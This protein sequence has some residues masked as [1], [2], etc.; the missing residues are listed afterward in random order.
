MRRAL[1]L[2]T[3]A[4]A[5]VA[6][7]VVGAAL[8][9]RLQERQA[10]RLEDRSG[11]PLVLAPASQIAADLDYP[12]GGIAVSKEGR[13]FVTLHP[14]GSPPVALVEMRG[15]TP[16]PYPNLEFQEKFASPLAT[17]IDGENRLWVLDYGSFGLWP[18]RLYIFYLDVDGLIEEH[19]LGDVAGLLSMFADF[20]IDPS[21]T[22][23][24]L[25]DSSPVLGNPSIVVYDTAKNSG[26][27][28]LEGHIA[29]Q[30]RAYVIQAP[31]REV[32]L[33]SGAPLAVAH[34]HVALDA[35]GE[36]LYIARLTG[37]R[38]Y[39]VRTADLKDLSLS[40]DE[41]ARRVEDV[42][43]KPLGGGM[44]S[45]VK[46]NLYISDPEHSAVIRVTPEGKL[47]T[48]L[49][50]SPLRWPGNISF[51][52]DGWLWVPCSSLHE[53]VL[54]PPGA[55]ETHRPYYIVRFKPGFEGV[56]GR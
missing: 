25:A 26:R 48:T 40:R 24:Y 4:I 31:G 3:F 17:R 34:V 36:W 21:G 27:R 52:P 53:I 39:R 5:A 55:V 8:F 10:Q 43:P 32:Y 33:P 56:P 54:R 6:L 51:G 2:T 50:D 45:D 7:L 23:A 47:E 30:G 37:D 14:A 46:G 42:A 20:Q 28:L 22:T 38:L 16:E 19:D 15:V 35:G 9:L 44:T 29:L 49:K 1:K 18:T 13:T 12:P 11:D 41:L